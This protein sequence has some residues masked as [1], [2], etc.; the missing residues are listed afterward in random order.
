MEE[1]NESIFWLELMA[2]KGIKT[3]G[4]K[5]QERC[6]KKLIIT[7]CQGIAHYPESGIM[8]PDKIQDMLE[9]MPDFAENQY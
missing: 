9:R 4:Q 1:R 8:A 7:D 5:L 6:G 2:S 3:L